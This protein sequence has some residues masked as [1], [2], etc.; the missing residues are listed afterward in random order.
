MAKLNG[1]ILLAQALKKEGV[2][3]VFTLTGGHI[4]PILYGC[5]D[6]G[7]KVVDGRHEGAVYLLTKR[8]KITII[9]MLGQVAAGQE[10]SHRTRDLET[11]EKG[12]V[13]IQ[14]LAAVQSVSDA[15]VAYTDK[16]GASRFAE[17]DLVVVSTGQRPVGADLALALEEKGIKV[18]RAGDAMAIG[19]I[20]ANVRSGFLA[21]Y[22]A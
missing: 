5:R 2:E 1:G 17:A 21:G 19:K 10:A 13:N 6:A 7:I 3:C 18:T 11:M 15:G 8:N 22:D 14:T 12:G 20:L 16:D 9:E 4:M